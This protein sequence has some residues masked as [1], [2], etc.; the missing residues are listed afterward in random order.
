[1]RFGGHSPDLGALGAVAKGT[2][3]LRSRARRREKAFNLGWLR[4]IYPH[5]HACRIGRVDL[6]HI[7]LMEDEPEQGQLLQ[8]MIEAAGHRVSLCLNGEEALHA[9]ASDGPDLLVTDLYVMRDGSVQRDG[10]VLLISRVR[11][12]VS[13]MGHRLNPRLPIIAISGGGA[14]PGGFSPL[15]LA[16]QVGAD[17]CL[18]KPIDVGELL[19][20]VQELTST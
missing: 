9:L 3:P 18:P 11:R 2:E 19:T 16:K 1:M 12:G 20:A 4:V 13:W 8:T 6:V 17:L 15:Q 10:G 14:I 5:S 7:V